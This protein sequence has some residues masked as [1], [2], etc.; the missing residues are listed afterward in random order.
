MCK[1]GLR[2]RG[3]RAR[4]L[5]LRLLTI[6]ERL[7]VNTVSRSAMKE[8]RKKLLGVR[9]RAARMAAG[10][11]QDHVAGA[12]G[13]TRQSVSAWETGASC[14]S[15]TQLAELS[16]LYCV[17]AHTLLFGEAYKPLSLAALMP[18]RVGFLAG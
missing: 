6:C 14:P 12:I 1:S 4:N 16:A 15:A 18:G 2:K 7:Y 3:L 5:L 17:C 9:L 13:V 11:S 8:Q 10:Q